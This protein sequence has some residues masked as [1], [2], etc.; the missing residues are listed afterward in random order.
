MCGWRTARSSAFPAVSVAIAKRPGT[1]AVAIAERI[2]E[3]LHEIERDYPARGPHRSDHPQLW[4]DGEREGE[5]ADLFHLGLATVSIVLL[6]GFA[7]G[8]REA[9]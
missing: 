1:N 8:W 4:R 7:I 2:T 6:V 3:R 5:R 9:P